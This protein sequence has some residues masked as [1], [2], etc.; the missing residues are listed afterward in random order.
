MKI[1]KYAQSCVLIETKGKRILIDP[2]QLKWEDSLLTK[3]WTNIDIILVTHKHGDH[4][5]LEAIKK[6]LQD[7]NSRFYTSQ[8][9]AN[10]IPELNPII[11][12]ENDVLN[13][14]DIKI[15]VVKAVHGYIPSFKGDKEIDEN[16]GFIIDDGGKRAYITSDSLCFKN[17]YK[18]NILL[19]A[20]SGHG[21][22]MGA[23]DA[24]LFAKETEASLVIP[25]H[26]DHPTYNISI[27]EIKQ[28]FEKNN[29]NYKFLEI[30]EFIE[31]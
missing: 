24:A 6:I 29:L 14:E 3:E 19:I 23:F 27:A 9:V 8:E 16:I 17:E 18:C 21:F 1:T 20:C 2:G 10:L 13:I 5:Y 15:E 22:I 28:E 31:I 7:F 30:K 12:K 11:V 4:C 25:T 26:Y